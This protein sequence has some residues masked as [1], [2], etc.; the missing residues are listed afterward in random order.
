MT[1]LL[2]VQAGPTPWEVEDRLVGDNPLPLT[3]LGRVTI[4]GIVRSLPYPLSVICRFKKNEACDQ[5]AKIMA[6]PY[7]IR[8]R[9]NVALN[10]VNLGLWQGLARSDVRFRFP[11]VFQEWEENPLAVTPPDGESLPDAIER[12]RGGLKRLLRRNRG[13]AIALPLRPMA[14]QIILGLLRREDIQTIAGHLHNL[15]AVETID[16]EDDDM[17]QF[18]S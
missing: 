5:A 12:L 7:G 16:I 15:A 9:D 2:L 17:Y 18:I 1:H 4:E 8:P 6:A 3:D 10:E 11:S 13:V 14:M